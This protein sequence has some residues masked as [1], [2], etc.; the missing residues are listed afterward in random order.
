MAGFSMF[1]EVIVAFMVGY[2]VGYTIAGLA[3]FI[4]NYFKS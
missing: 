1:L 4:I 3:R 2:V